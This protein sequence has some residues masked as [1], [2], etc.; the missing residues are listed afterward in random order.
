[1]L[2]SGKMGGK[3]ADLNRLFVGLCRFVG[4]PARDVYGLHPAPS[5]FGYKESG[6]N[7]DDSKGAQDCR[8]E[9][10]L[11]S[12]GCVATDRADVLKVM[13]QESSEWVKVLRHPLVA[14]VKAGLFGSGEGN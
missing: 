14:P 6:G 9:V 10:C 11:K 3:C 13:R 4:I 8:A 2:Q 5:A 12:H 7:L 1:M